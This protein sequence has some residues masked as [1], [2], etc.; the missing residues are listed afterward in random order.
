[1]NKRAA[2]LRL[3][4]QAPAIWADGIGRNSN[5]HGNGRSPL[6]RLAIRP[7]SL[8]RR[9]LSS[10]AL[11]AVCSCIS[12]FCRPSHMAQYPYSNG[13]DTEKYTFTYSCS[14]RKTV[15]NF[16]CRN[17]EKAGAQE[18]CKIFHLAPCFLPFSSLNSERY[19]SASQKSS[20]R[21]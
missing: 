21:R 14:K 9:Y 15:Y 11:H 4:V 2:R 13:F 16:K 10:D 6:N 7:C 20:T 3:A 8:V 17:G 12:A 18:N 1:M 5:A 19:F